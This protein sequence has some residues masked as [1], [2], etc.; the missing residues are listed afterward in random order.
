MASMVDGLENELLNGL[1]GVAQ[2]TSP[3]ELFLA[4]FTAD[5]T[6]TG[7]VV[8]EQAGSGYARVSLTGSFSLATGT[9]GVSANTSIISFP[10]ALADWTDSTHAGIMKTGVA[11]TDDMIL[12]VNLASLVVTLSGEQFAFL[13]GDLSLTLA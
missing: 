11:G 10:V 13:V 5:P 2:Y 3:P 6:D 9:T 4:L 1:L 8:N 7:S 12:V